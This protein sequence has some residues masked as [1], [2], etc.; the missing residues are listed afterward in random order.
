M[1]YKES[2]EYVGS[3]GRL[4]RTG[5]TNQ[6]ITVWE[7][8]RTWVGYVCVALVE[9]IALQGVRSSMNRCVSRGVVVGGVDSLSFCLGSCCMGTIRRGSVINWVCKISLQGLRGVVGEIRCGKNEYG[10]DSQSC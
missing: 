2:V 3:D 6:W 5:R 9:D 4:E 7:S 8:V 10:R 1:P